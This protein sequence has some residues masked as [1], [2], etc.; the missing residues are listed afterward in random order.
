MSILITNIGELA[1]AD[2]E[3][4]LIPDAALVV[5][6]ERSRGPGRRRG[7]GR[8]RGVRRGRPGGAARV[9]RLHAHLVFA[10]ERAEEF[11]ARMSG[12]PYAAGGIRTT[13]EK[14]RAASDEELGANVRRLVAE[15]ARQGT[16]TVECKSG[17][18]LTVG[19]RSV[20][21]GSP[22]GWSTRSP[23]W[24]RMSS[25]PARPGRVRRLVAGDAAGLRAVRAM[26]R[27]VL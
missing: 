15:M 8:R 18:G 22:P 17:Y 20:R 11:A 1:G 25:R 5:D 16:T 10:G 27:R 24:A 12:R 2:E 9:R 4:W 3:R 6:G 23:T 13:V 19:T 7:A 21:Y 26:D 14:T